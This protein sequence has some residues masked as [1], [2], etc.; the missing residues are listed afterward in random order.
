MNIF[1]AVSRNK[2]QALARE[3]IAFGQA[4]SESL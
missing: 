4:Q 2:S 1:A 3:L